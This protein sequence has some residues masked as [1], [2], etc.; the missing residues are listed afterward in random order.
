MAATSAAPAMARKTPHL[1]LRFLSRFSRLSFFSFLSFFSRFSL[2][3]RFRLRPGLTDPSRPCLPR[4]RRPR[5]PSSESEPEVP[6]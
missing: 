2:L 6:A 1:L 5:E 4:P 3:D